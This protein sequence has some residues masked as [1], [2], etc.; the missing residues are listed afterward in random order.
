MKYSDIEKDQ[1]PQSREGAL[2]LATQNHPVI[3]ACKEHIKEAEAQYKGSF[4][5][6]H[7]EVEFELSADW[8]KN[9]KNTEKRERVLS[10]MGNV[11]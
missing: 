4:S 1:M 3:F 8:Q 9:M 6:D 2:K 7:P 5:R 11:T 10:A